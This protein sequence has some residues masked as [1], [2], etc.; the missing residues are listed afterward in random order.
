[1]QDA[2]VLHF[3]FDKNCKVEQESIEVVG[4]ME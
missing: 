2:D 4:K 3:V 1:M